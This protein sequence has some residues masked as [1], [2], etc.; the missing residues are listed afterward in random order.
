MTVQEHLDAA[1]NAFDAYWAESLTVAN[2]GFVPDQDLMD[3][4]KFLSK[5]AFM[6]GWQG[7]LEN[8]I[9]IAANTAMEALRNV[10]LS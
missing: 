9:T 7:G 1:R 8:G 2:L 3:V 6:A 4:M 5:Q 10:N